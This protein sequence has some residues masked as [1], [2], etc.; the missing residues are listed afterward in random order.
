MLYQDKSGNPDNDVYDV[1]FQVIHNYGHGGSG[2]TLC[3]G[4]ALDAVDIFRKIKSEEGGARNPA[5]AK[6]SL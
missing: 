2:I 4:S 6:S 3:W 5:S 1:V